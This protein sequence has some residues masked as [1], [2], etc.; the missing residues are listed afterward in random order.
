MTVSCSGADGAQ[1]EGG[2]AATRKG[3]RKLLKHIEQ[4]M[5]GP[6]W[7]QPDFKGTPPLSL[8]RLF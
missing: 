7:F 5:G 2:G 3:E 4:E 6:G 1:V 8:S